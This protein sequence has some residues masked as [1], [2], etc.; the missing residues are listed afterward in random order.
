MFKQKSEADCRGKTVHM[1]SSQ[2][3]ESSSGTW[4]A[5]PAGCPE[6]P[7]SLLLP[8]QLWGPP[9]ALSGLSALKSLFAHWLWPTPNLRPILP[10]EVRFWVFTLSLTLSLTLA[11]ALRCSAVSR[12]SATPL[13]ARTGGLHG[14]PPA[15][16]R[17]PAAVR[18]A[19]LCLAWWCAAATGSGR[20]CITFRDRTLRLRTVFTDTETGGVAITLLNF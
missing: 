16:M 4:R 20:Y 15:A 14:D 1:R 17:V 8:T 13:R 2:E 3:D 19:K 10:V 12:A 9:Q 18:G 7:A 6:S 5:L 11:V